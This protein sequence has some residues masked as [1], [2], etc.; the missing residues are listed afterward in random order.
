MWFL[1]PEFW[2]TPYVSCRAIIWPI[3]HKKYSN[4]SGR[5]QWNLHSTSLL[6][7]GWTFV[8]WTLCELSTCTKP[9][10]KLLNWHTKCSIWKAVC[11]LWI[12]LVYFSWD[13]G[14]LHNCHERLLAAF[15]VCSLSVLPP[16]KAV[17][18]RLNHC[19]LLFTACV[20]VWLFVFLAP[21]DIVQQQFRVPIYQQLLWW[22]Q[23]FIS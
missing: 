5:L 10:H 4:L 12:I 17:Q 23:C 21:S 18:I 9:H 6:P 7:M 22:V 2:Y 15:C 14:R 3:V 8:F 11:H 20:I 13:L 1:I 16:N 19:L